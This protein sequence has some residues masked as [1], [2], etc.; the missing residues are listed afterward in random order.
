MSSGTEGNYQHLKALIRHENNP[1][2]QRK[3]YMSREWQDEL[4]KEE[5]TQAT[6]TRF[7]RDLSNERDSPRSVLTIT[8]SKLCP[9]WREK[10]CEWQ[11]QVVDR[12]DL[13]REIV[14]ISTFYLDRYLCMFFADEDLFQLLSMT[15]LYLAIKIHSPIKLS[16]GCMARLG[17]GFISVAHITEMEICVM[18]ALG[19]YL[20]PPTPI[21]FLD[22]FFPIISQDLGENNRS[23]FVDVYEFSRFLAEL[24]V[25]AYPFVAAMP[26]SIA[27]AAILFSIEHFRLCEETI[28][29]FE[30]VTGTLN[31]DIDS[32]EVVECKKLLRKVYKSAVSQD[33]LATR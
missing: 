10:I 3:Y 6:N 7:R 4:R 33:L 21:A 9:T 32:Y 15:C 29:S 22:N 23:D 20:Y 30:K 31:L 13:D 17:R 27:I 18:Q 12:Y 25:C 2:Y 24:S 14:G 19:W 26:S 11:Y 5:V 1:V 16:I 8:S 28:D